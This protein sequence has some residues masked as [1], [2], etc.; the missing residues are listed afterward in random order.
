M[1]G[2]FRFQLFL[3]SEVYFEGQKTVLAMK[4]YASL[5]E[6]NIG[7][8]GCAHQR[9]VQRQQV[10]IPCLLR[11]PQQQSSVRQSEFLKFVDSGLLLLILQNS[12]NVMMITV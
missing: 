7:F 9:H 1:I 5:E 8:I 3:Q 6:E 10:Q 4:L 2:R 11:R 12:V